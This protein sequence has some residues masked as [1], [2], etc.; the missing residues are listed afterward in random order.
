MDNSEALMQRHVIGPMWNGNFLNKKLQKKYIKN[1]YGKDSSEY[2]KMLKHRDDCENGI[3]I[4]SGRVTDYFNE[5][6]LSP[7]HTKKEFPYIPSFACLLS[8]N[9]NETINGFVEREISKFSE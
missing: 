4:K 7:L 1:H 6:E 8:K 5:I 2:R 9:K 3:V